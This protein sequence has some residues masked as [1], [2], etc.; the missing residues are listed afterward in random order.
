MH[1]A[2]LIVIIL[3]TVSM[4][5]SC[6]LLPDFC[7]KIISLLSR[8]NPPKTLFVNVTALKKTMQVCCHTNPY[9]FGS[10][11]GLIAAIMTFKL[12]RCQLSIIFRR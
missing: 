10:S 12:D 3:I 9:A 7:T 11:Q 5:T 2:W 4:P 1:F 8:W 6:R